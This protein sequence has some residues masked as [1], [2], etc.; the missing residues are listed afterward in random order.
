MGNPGLTLMR[1]V[2][3]VGVLAGLFG[4]LALRLPPFAIVAAALVA[5]VCLREGVYRGL[6][7]TLIGGALVAAGW[8]TLGSRP[9]LAFPLVLPLWPT[10]LLMAEWVR[11]G[12]SLGTALAVAGAVMV[13][14]V[15]F[16][17]F[18]TGDVVGFWH[19]WLTRAVA[20]VPGATVK[21]FEDNDTVRLMNGFMA[22]LLGLALFLA[23][24]LG[25]WMQ[26]LMSGRP[27]FAAEFRQ[28]ALPFWFLPVMVT[29]IWAGGV[30]DP[31]LLAD[32]LMVAILLYAFVGLAVL[33]GVLAVRGQSQGWALPAYVLL[34]YFPPQALAALALVGAVDVF[35]RFRVQQPADR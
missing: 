6:L 17:H 31:I 33:H 15:A 19:E 16:M 24:L 8:F 5:L 30:V 23:L 32:L 28:L 26:S 9:G 4:V 22:L 14:F 3:G 7:V 1:S 29:L 10:V 27:R 13:S 25:R 35:V 34:V 20:A 18:L 21:G 11:R 12:R 2:G